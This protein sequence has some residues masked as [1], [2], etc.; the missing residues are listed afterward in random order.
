MSRSRLVAVLAAAALVGGAAMAAA[1]TSL[2]Y[3]SS[4]EV[5]RRDLLLPLDV[6][7]VEATVP[8]NATL[9]SLLK[10]HPASSPFADSIVGA[11]RTVFNPRH[12]QADRPYRVTTTLDGLFRE[13][14]YRLDSDRFLRVALKDDS[15][16]DAPE[17]HVEVVPYPK[18]VV[19][20]AVE[21]EITKAR[22]SLA[23]AL[24]DQGENI[25]LA[26]LLADA[27]SGDVDFNSDL[28]D[29]DR[30]EVLFGRVLRDG[31][32]SGY[33]AVH[34]AVY[35]S[36]GRTLTAIRHEGPDGR[37]A[38]YD[39]D[40]RSRVRQFLK[41][42]LEFQPF[43]TSRFSNSRLHPV[44][45]VYRAH[46]GVDYRAAYGTKVLAVSSGTVVAAG[47]AGGA[48]RR[49]V[50]KH[51]GGYESAYFHLSA[52][53]P[54]ITAGAK[55]AQGQVIGRVGD[56]GTVTATHLHYELKKNGVHVNPVTEHRNMPPGVPI[57]ADQMPAF[58][59]ARERLFGQ[60][61][62]ALSPA[63]AAGAVSPAA[64]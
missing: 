35:H 17:F 1:L 41:S 21:V 51:A 50:I 3:D 57:P 58:L 60:L 64:Q 18:E 13:F 40:G 33:E 43:V 4:S 11:V 31:R 20:E 26:L 34:A 10:S 24:Q 54:G 59:D 45:G 52:F 42:P 62:Q 36:A 44:L 48:G 12:L 53:G 32:F 39:A 8:R 6:A 7:I 38:W 63:S 46:R 19:T 14:R 61:R 5:E 23:A 37:M 22:P 47:W 16:A 2:R 27:F 9:E 15:S 29:G 28:Q 25:Q 56:S 30:F 55:V 49:V